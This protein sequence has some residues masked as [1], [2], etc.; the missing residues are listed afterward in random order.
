MIELTVRDAGARLDAYIADVLDGL[1]R[2]QAQ[3]W[4]EEGAVT[5][6]GRVLK[7]SYKV[8]EGDQ[9]Q[10]IPPDIK[11]THLIPEAIPL[12]IVFEDDDLLV[13]NKPKGMVVHPAPGAE[14]GTLVHALLAHAPGMLSV[15][16][17][18]ERPGIVHRLDKDTSGLLMVAKNDVAHRALQA[19]IQSR[20]AKRT[21][22]AFLWGNP[23]YD[24]AV[25]E[26]PIGRHPNDR[27]KMT[28]ARN[29]DGRDAITDLKVLERLGLITRVEC[30]LRHGRTHQIRVH[31]QFA[32]YPVVGD[33]VYGGIR[34]S[35][36]RALDLRVAALKGQALHASSLAFLHPRTGEPLSFETPLPPPLA[37]FLAYLRGRE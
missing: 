2:A 23:P 22:M 20:E 13:V 35:G 7:G 26:A 36:D 32:G 21:Y 8:Q 14:E 1:S 30:R 29:D 17:G 18:E 27:L 9:L 16:G 5:V 3:R 4:I 25:I 33:A 34:R 11:P 10:L 37:E 24:E 31:C 15:I 19:Q 12:E 6:N 28:V